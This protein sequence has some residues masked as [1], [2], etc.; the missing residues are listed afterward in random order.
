MSAIR[1]ID[2]AN[3]TDIRKNESGFNYYLML[4]AGGSGIIMR[5][6]TAETE[7]RFFVFGGKNTPDE[8]ETNVDA[9]F[10]DRANKDYVRPSALK[11]L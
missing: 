2:G 7:Y 11:N 10:A 4:R 1:I 3:V 5:E 6:N 8:A 9:I